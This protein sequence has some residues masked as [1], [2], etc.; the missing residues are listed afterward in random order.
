MLLLL[1]YHQ[2]A[3][4]DPRVQANGD[5]TI[6]MIPSVFQFTIMNSIRDMWNAKVYVLGVLIAGTGKSPCKNT[7]N[8]MFIY[9]C[10][11]V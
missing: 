1:Y 3:S 5:T 9:N 2:G 8:A 10:T 6:F 11:F 4:V 7:N